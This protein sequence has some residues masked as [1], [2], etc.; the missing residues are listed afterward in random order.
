MRANSTA[1]SLF[2]KLLASRSRVVSRGHSSSMGLGSA[3]GVCS[4]L[5]ASWQKYLKK[6][7]AFVGSGYMP[8]LIECAAAATEGEDRRH[9]EHLGP[10]VSLPASD[11]TAEGDG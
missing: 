1:L 5:L 4:S 2:E 9:S 8:R 6:R 3:S 11:D 10:L 7:S